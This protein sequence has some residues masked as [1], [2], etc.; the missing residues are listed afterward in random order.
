MPPSFLILT[1]L[2]HDSQQQMNEKDIKMS[3]CECYVMTNPKTKLESSTTHELNLCPM[4][5]QQQMNEPD[6]KMSECACYVMTSP[7]T[8]LESSTT[9]GSSVSP[10]SGL[11]ELPLPPK[12]FKPD[13]QQQMNE[14]DIKMSKC[15]CYVMTSPETKLESSTTCESNV[16]PM[17]AL[18]EQPLPPRKLKPDSQQQMNEQDIKMSKCACYVMTSPETKLESSTK[19]KSSQLESAGKQPL[20]EV[21]DQPKRGRAWLSQ[22]HC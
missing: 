4:P 13:S 1:K 9:C 8:K 5:A 11:N 3:E 2:K 14:P 17:S 18:N 15:A 10:T 21:S 20:S 12:K 22:H 6:I 7:E 16:S 19:E